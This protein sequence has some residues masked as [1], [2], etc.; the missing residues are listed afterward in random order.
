MTFPRNLDL[1]MGP[2]LSLVELTTCSL[3]QN[4]RLAHKRTHLMTL[5]PWLVHIPLVF[6]KRVGICWDYPLVI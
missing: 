1:F 6:A 4:P 5:L 2:Q 3:F